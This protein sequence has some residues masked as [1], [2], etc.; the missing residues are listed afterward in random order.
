MVLF[1]KL[2]ARG[3]HDGP[4]NYKPVRGGGICGPDNKHVIYSVGS[5]ELVESD[6]LCLGTGVGWDLSTSC[7]IIR[8]QRV[9]REGGNELAVPIVS[10]P[11]FI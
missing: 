3:T 1:A 5:A 8:C 7:P 4:G 9:G 11:T 2:R 6:C 10:A